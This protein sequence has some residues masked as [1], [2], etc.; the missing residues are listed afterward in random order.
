M[1]KGTVLVV[2]SAAGE[3]QLKSGKMVAIGV[4]L[5]E[6]AVP[7]M[8]LLK[9]GYDIVLATPTG[10]RPIMDPHSKDASHFGNSE[11]AF[12]AATQFVES[13]PKMIAPKK[14][15][16]VIDEGLD[17]FSAVFVPGGHAP[18]VDLSQDA[19]FGE[20][21]RYFHA[22]AKPTALLCHGPIALI[23]SV[24]EMQ[25]FRTA[26]ESDDIAAAKTAAVGWIY[27]GYKMTIFSNDEEK[28]AEKELLHGQM[29]FYVGDA[30]VAA[31]GVLTS[32]TR[33]FDPHVTQDRELITG[34][35]P[36]SDHAIADAL[37]KAL[38]ES[39]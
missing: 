33:P 11:E 27:T 17:K 18:I 12:R 2:S 39:A 14:L 16:A 8:A 25:K 6:I 10:T 35:N 4:Y 20:V 15:R 3:L 5:N 21:L 36:A 23:A 9:A 24:P 26:M 13:D 32:N 37:I 7:T 34:Q 30:L 29:K 28:Y 31:G 19:D 1:S 22:Q 38:G